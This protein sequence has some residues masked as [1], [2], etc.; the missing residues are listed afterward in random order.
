[1]QPGAFVC[2]HLSLNGHALI[3]LRV[4]DTYLPTLSL[5]TSTLGSWD[6]ASESGLDRQQVLL[7]TRWAK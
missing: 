6:A 5:V 7:W 1:M 4:I 2:F 3:T